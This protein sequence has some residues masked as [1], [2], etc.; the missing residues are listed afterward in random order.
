MRQFFRSQ[1]LVREFDR[2]CLPAA[3]HAQIRG[4]LSQ[5]RRL[6]QIFFFSRIRGWCYKTI[7]QEY[8]PA[9]FPYK[10]G[11]Y[12]RTCSC[13]DGHAP[14][15]FSM[16]PDFATESRNITRSSRSNIPTG[17]SL[18]VDIQSS[19][20][21]HGAAL[22]LIAKQY[23]TRKVLRRC[24]TSLLCWLLH[25]D[26]SNAVG[27]SDILEQGSRSAGLG[28]HGRSAE[29]LVVVVASSSSSSLFHARVRSDAL[30]STLPLPIA[31]NWVHVKVI[32]FVSAYSEFGC[33]SCANVSHRQRL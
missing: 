8:R 32:C 27:W 2:S 21:T 4:A 16:F 6:A 9:R 33:A 22:V 5:P 17:F 10:I 15:P 19:C 23:T 11:P 14:R 24:V 3:Y 25:R 12:R 29:T 31:R 1:I 20:A 7:L 13:A 18:D 26:H 30:K 28:T